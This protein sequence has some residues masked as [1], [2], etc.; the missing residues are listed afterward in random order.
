MKAIGG[1][2]ELE[3]KYGKEIHSDAIALNSG[4][5]ALLYILKA[6]GYKRIFIPFYTCDVVLEPLKKLGLTFEFYQI[7]KNFEPLFNYSQ[8]DAEDAF[9]YTNYFGLKGSFIKDLVSATKN[10][11]IDN[12]QAYF[13][14][15]MPNTD[16][17]YS[18]RKFLGLPDGGY[19]YTNTDL[20]TLDLDTEDSA[21]RCTHLLKRIDKSAEEGYADFQK[22]DH[23]ISSLPL[24]RMSKLTKRIIQS[25]KHQHIADRRKSNYNYLEEQLG[26]FNQLNMQLDLGA[27]PMVYPFVCDFQDLQKALASQKI[28][29]AK[30]WPNTQI[31]VPESGTEKLFLKQLLGLPIDQR[32]SMEEMTFVAHT[33]KQIINE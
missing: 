13:S 25:A 19:A 4:R 9:L 26:S 18:P 23:E 7:N 1:Y 16:T 29:C 15:P 2:F 8:L 31:P 3:L 24:K 11:I 20:E 14:M 28:Y 30:Y 27:V 6:R 22:N 32:Y 21:E 10:V 5:N 33:I 17:F 12:S